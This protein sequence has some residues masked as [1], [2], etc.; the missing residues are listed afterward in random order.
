MLFDK[1]TLA[2]TRTMS[3]HTDAIT[4][5]KSVEVLA[6][7]NRRGLISSGRDGRIRYVS[8][9]MVCAFLTYSGLEYGTSEQVVQ[10]HL[11]V[12]S[13]LFFGSPHKLA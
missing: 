12:G 4:S 5:L 3:G 1:A 11:Q 6:G 7:T 9:Q 10:V 8:R 13:I 2:A